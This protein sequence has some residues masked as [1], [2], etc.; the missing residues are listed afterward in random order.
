[1]TLLEEAMAVVENKAVNNA[2]DER[3]ILGWKA[4]VI[5]GPIVSN[6]NSFSV[7]VNLQP[8]KVRLL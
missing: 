4:K 3:V 2:A 1:M 5:I 8:H 7:V 6:S